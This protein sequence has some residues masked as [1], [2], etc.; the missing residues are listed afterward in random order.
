MRENLQ[1]CTFNYHG[2]E[3]V[4]IELG[5][6]PANHRKTANVHVAARLLKKEAT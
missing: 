5:S 3:L 6:F 2:A 4:L 1:Q